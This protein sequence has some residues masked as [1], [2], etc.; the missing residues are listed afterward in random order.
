MKHSMVHRLILVL[1]VSLLALPCSQAAETWTPTASLGTARKRHT[2]TL[3]PNGKLLVVGGYNGNGA[4]SSAELYDPTTGTWTATG[5]LLTGRGVHTATLLPNGKI[6]VVGGSSSGGAI[7]SAELYDPSTG[8]WIVTGSLADAR[9]NHT[10]TLLP[11][12]KLLVAGGYGSSYLASVE[13]YDPSTGTW[14]AAA[15]LATARGYH[16]ATLLQNSKVLVVGGTNVASAEL[17][18]AETGTWNPTGSLTTARSRH[19][20]TLLTDGKVL[21]AGGVGSSYL[22]S[23]ALYNPATGIWSTT[24]FLSNAHGDHTATLLTDGRVLVAGG[25]GSASLAGTELYEPATG[26]WNAISNLLT[27]RG[28]YTATLLPNSRVLVAG[29]GGSSGATLALAEVFSNVHLVIGN[30]QVAQRS[31]TDLVDIDYDFSGTAA[32]VLVSLQASADGGLT[33]TVPLT[34]LTGA[35]G[36]N[37][38]PG[39]GLR[40]TWDAG[41]DWDNQSSNQFRIKITASDGQLSVD[42]TSGP[43]SL[44]TQE[45]V[46]LTVG[47]LDQGTIEGVATGGEYVIG[48]TAEFTAVANPGYTFSGWTGDATGTANPL[49]LLMDADKMIGATFA[50]DLADTDTDGMP[51]WW[52][53]ANNL[54]PDVNDASG[55]A[56]SDGVTNL[57]EFQLSFNPRDSDSDDDG[58]L[59]GAEDAETDGLPDVWELRL[60]LNRLL[61]DSNGNGVTDANEDSDGDEVTNMW[62]LALSL[63]PLLPD[64]NGNGT[65]DA[66]EDADGDGL[67]N[68][69][70][71]RCGL[72]PLVSD[73][74]QTGDGSDGPLDV[75]AGTTRVFAPWMT[76]VTGSNPAGASQVGV[77]DVTGF[78][79]ND[80]VLLWVAQD[81]EPA[82]G[83][84][85]AGRYQVCR[86][87]AKNSNSLS[88]LPPLNTDFSAAAGRVLIAQGIPEY[89]T[90][91]VHGTLEPPSWNGTQGGI[92]AF[93]AR[94][95]VIRPSGRIHANG[96]GFRGGADYAQAD[97]DGFQGETYFP[98][99]GLRLAT[100]NGGGGGGGGRSYYSS[101][102]G[103]GGGGYGATGATGGFEPSNNSDR[104]TSKTGGSGGGVTGSQNLARLVIGSGGG[105]GGQD[106]NDPGDSGLNGGSGGNGGGMILIFSKLIANAGVISSNGG[107]GSNALPTERGGGGGGSGGTVYL[108]GNYNGTGNLQSLGGTGG[109]GQYAQIFGGNGG[110]GRIRADLQV[111]APVVSCNPPVGFLGTFSDALSTTGSALA[112]YDDADSDSLDTLQESKANTNPFKAD[113]D[114]DLMDD[115]WE[116]ANGLDPRVVDAQLDADNDDLSNLSEY[117]LHTSPIAADSD[118]DGVKDGPEVMS[119]T[120]VFLSDTDGDGM[121]DGWEIANGLNP[122]VNDASGD[123]DLDGL[124]NKEEYDQRANGYK[125]NAINSLAGTAGDDH[126]SDYRRLKGENWTR[127]RY[128]RND[129]IIATERDNGSAQIYTYD[130]NS[131]KRRDILSAT[132]D[133]DG[134]GLPDSWEFANNLAYNETG[135]ASGINGATGDPDGDGFTNEAE[136]RSNTNPRDP[137]SRITTG[138]VL[139]ATPAVAPPG[140]NP[141]NWVMATG[142]INGYGAEEVVIGADGSIGSANNYLSLLTRTGDTWASLDIPAG[143]VGIT[144]LATGIKAAGSDP[145]IFIGTRPPTGSGSITEFN[146]SGSTWGK[147]TTPVT[148]TSGTTIAQVIGLSNQTLLTLQSPSGL[149]ADGIYKQTYS[150]STWSPASSV[151]NAAGKRD[152][153]I[154]KDGST[155]RW[156]DSGGIQ[157][158]GTGGP[159]SSLS[160]LQ[161]PG[162]SNWYFLTPTVMTW[163]QAEAFA[164]EKGGHLVTINDAEENAWIWSQFGT[165]QPLWLGLYRTPNASLSTGWQW[166]SGSSSQYRKW[167]SGE[168][169]G[170]GGIASAGKAIMWLSPTPSAWNDVMDSGSIKGLV[171][172]DSAI[173]GTRSF[174]DPLATA[175]LIWRG[176]SFAIG[177]L[178][179]DTTNA[180]SLVSAFIDD[181]DTS[182]AA[183]SGD[184]FV[185]GEYHLISTSPVQRTSVR[186][187]LTSPN[188]AGAYGLTTL[189]RID[190]TKPAVLAVGEP[191]GTVSLWSAPDSTS[192]LV[193]KVFSTEFKGKSWHQLEPL[194]E[195]NGREGLVGL[196]VDPATP[197][198][199]QVIHWSPEAIEAALNGT[200]P[201]LNNLPLARLL[202]TPSSGAAQATVGVRAWD[203]EAHDSKFTLQFQAP[204]T[205]VWT[206]AR[207]LSADGTATKLSTLGNTTALATAPGGLSH[208]LVWNAAADLGSSFVGTVLLRTMATDTE[209]GAWSEPVPYAIDLVATLDSDG[210]GFTNGQELAFGTDPNS[211]ASRPVLTTVRNPNGSLQLT[212]PTAVG[213]TYRLETSIDLTV[214]TTQQSGLSTNT[215]SIPLAQLSAHKRFYRIAAE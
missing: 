126:L 35:V 139:A 153:A 171:E 128:D 189:R 134:D 40:I 101:G 10:A 9:A 133:A 51:N 13:L 98:G 214:W 19:T 104:S 63:S 22:A 100:A 167:D 81:S 3:L 114:G 32:P 179:T 206:N 183:N 5:S 166:I 67:P 2:A 87:V 184:E 57:E 127:R 186:I 31:G 162:T 55:D 121:N 12:G 83:A 21:V 85:V 14:S 170:D 180:P 193:R 146:Q 198:Q 59:D 161:R 168:P 138:A 20:A 118:G 125:A 39:T 157:V 75:P 58:I 177:N 113:T 144:S 88:L 210:D 215:L 94:N 192:P 62:E 151:N 154:T 196:L 78:A 148:T 108:V 7:A 187:P 34:S 42:T 190:T 137:L 6:I 136:W 211:A 1:L 150:S 15:P 29:G 208:T 61:P 106:G 191:D 112:S 201:V 141:T 70:E 111:N 135:A 158:L 64:S 84:N 207:L 91:T 25:Y 45:W 79:I 90:V 129:R 44:D 23:A 169:N 82:A 27:G 30:V 173:V 65:R 18:D 178:R 202:P 103:G 205:G 142:Q 107:N 176:H 86:I 175:K 95:L 77:A 76:S 68:G 152:W 130:G 212:W 97:V 188:A 109:T 93:C 195:S 123:R 145:S 38:T 52:E 8:T 155:A 174:P 131:Q 156:L 185:I 116:M 16:S 37:V 50:L 17:Y 119:G 89:T 36:A 204:A 74:N 143:N 54:V 164:V 159:D 181:K 66:Q 165:S 60:G 69:W 132:L 124:T 49:S 122:L 120:G 56:D 172:L 46:H 160:P 53:V 200:A 194:R 117:L 99:Y 149:A 72:N 203:A 43:I 110:V 199:C 48:A 96:K 24:S 197:G 41:A 209:A 26:T 182:G 102:N 71:I 80:L 4:T 11:N 140:F 47:A 213:K 163:S 92:L 147:I 28:E 105:S 33:W 115:A 73:K